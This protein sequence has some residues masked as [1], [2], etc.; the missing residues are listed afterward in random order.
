LDL[1]PQLRGRNAL[2]TGATA[3]LG[4]AIADAL[5]GAGA[6]V[7]LHSQHADDA[8]RAAQRALA[9]KHGARVLLLQADLREADQ[10]ET[11][12]GQALDELPRLDIL[13]NNAVIRHFEPAHELPRAHWDESLAVNLSAAFHL[14]RL[15]LPG[16]LAR[17]WGR[18]VNLSSV[19]GSGATANRV[20][21]VTTKTALLGLTRALAIET[22]A[23]G[24][25]CNA[26]APGTAP[27]PAI[28]ARIG[29]IARRQGIPMEQAE[30]DYLA[31]R[32]PT[33]R[34]VAMENVAALILFLC[35]EA[36]RDITGAALPIDGGWTAA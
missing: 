18:I 22:A 28:L 23:R 27:T 10:I 36:G 9:Q 26:V 21:Y 1:T 2:V 20:G 13:V 19:Y 32:Q 12:V 33:G 25:T 15:A 11:L 8:A 3:G 35:S 16:M 14:A 17:Q 31:A 29:E 24:V 4:H 7:V 6:T 30:H 34:F 5:A